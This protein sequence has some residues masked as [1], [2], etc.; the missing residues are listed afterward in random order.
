M[1]PKGNRIIGP[2]AA[3]ALVC[4]FL[5]W[6][7]VSC[8]G[9]PMASFSG[10]QLA[11]GGNIQTGFG[12]QP[13]EGSPVLFLVLLAA[14]GCLALVYFGYQRQIVTRTGAYIA[15]GLAGASLL[16]LLAKFSGAQSQATQPGVTVKLQYG[17]WGTVLANV[18][19]IIGAV[20]DLREE[21]SQTGPN[22]EESPPQ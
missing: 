11:A 2:A 6:V 16:I 5:P 19:I 15:T 4:F 9:Q 10:W 18:A 1:L 13:I 21:G 7:L 20:L 22:R 8:G 14:I 12:T 3:I 17:L